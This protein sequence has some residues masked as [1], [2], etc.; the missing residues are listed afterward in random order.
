[1]I[2]MY[3]RTAKL[4]GGQS[5]SF[6]GMSRSVITRPLTRR[7]VAAPGPSLARRVGALQ[8]QSADAQTNC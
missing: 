2:S 4:S 5:T 8:G 3:L 1:M 7:V 6:C